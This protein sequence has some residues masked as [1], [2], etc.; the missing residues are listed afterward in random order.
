MNATEI[1]FGGFGGQGVILA[2]III[3]RAASIYDNKF[4]TL[5][6]SFGPEA[7]GSACSAQ[8]IVSDERVMYPYVTKP[9]ILMA[10]SQ[11]ACNKFL[12]ETTD[13]AILIIEKELV[14]PKNVKP[15]MKVYAIPATRIAEEMGRKMILNIVMVGF[16][17]SV[18]G[19][20]NHEAV[21]EAVRASVPMG[22][23]VMNLKAFDRGFQYGEELKKGTV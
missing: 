16:F 19:L 12:P 1:K 8:V 11:E 6:Q 18:T 17:T 20:I 5:T 3:G 14:D 10:M 9:E 2:G 21:R 13:D 22:T 4:A 15:G 23:E 7:R